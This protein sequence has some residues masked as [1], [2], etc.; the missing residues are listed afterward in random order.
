M[1]EAG[2]LLVDHDLALVKVED[3][4]RVERGRLDVEAEE[5]SVS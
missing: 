1:R 2:D 3:L 5:G 4:E